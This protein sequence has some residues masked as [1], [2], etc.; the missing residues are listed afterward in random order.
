MKTIELID[1]NHFQAVCITKS[2][3]NNYQ[4]ISRALVHRKLFTGQRQSAK[5]DANNLWKEGNEMNCHYDLL[6]NSMHLR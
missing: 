3:E 5:Y 2:L 1:E 6:R 4:K